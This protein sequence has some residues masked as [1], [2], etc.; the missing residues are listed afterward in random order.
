MADYLHLFLPPIVK[1]F[2]SQDVPIEIRKQAL[3]TIERLSDV[4]DFSE[5][6]S[7]IIHPLVRCLETT[8]DLRPTAMDTLSALVYQLGMYDCYYDLTFLAQCCIANRMQVL[9]KI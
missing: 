6:A 5:F 2:D 4:L 9:L 8:P 3:E 1:L 7:R